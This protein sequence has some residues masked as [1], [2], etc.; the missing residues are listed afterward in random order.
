MS[1]LG[2]CGPLLPPPP[3]LLPFVPGATLVL[4]APRGCAREA[5]REEGAEP[6]MSA[7]GANYT[8]KGAP[9][10]DESA[11]FGS[12]TRPSRLRWLGRHRACR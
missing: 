12:Q 6:S 3:P 8:S 10:V 9:T 7:G 1:G 2:V 11:L 4:R 5:G